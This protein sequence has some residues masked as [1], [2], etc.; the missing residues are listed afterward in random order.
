MADQVE[1]AALVFSAQIDAELAVGQRAAAPR[2]DQIQRVHIG[3]DHDFRLRRAQRLLRLMHLLALVQTLF[4]FLQQQMGGLADV[5]L[6]I[7][8]RGGIF[9]AN[10]FAPAFD[11]QGI[12]GETS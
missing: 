6:D 3:I 10:P 1:L 2:Y 11:A 4:G 9:V 5:E 7:P 8:H 12:H